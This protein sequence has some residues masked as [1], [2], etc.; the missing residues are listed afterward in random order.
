MDRREGSGGGVGGWAAG[1]IADPLPPGETVRVRTARRPVSRRASILTVVPI[2]IGALLGP[3][4]GATTTPTDTAVRGAP[5]WSEAPG[6]RSARTPDVSV[7]RGRRLTL[8]ATA[9]TRTLAGKRS[10]RTG[11]SLVVGVPTPDRKSTRLNSSH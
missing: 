4:A 5:E 7:S 9:L 6:A 10:G 11:E 1:W 3:A 8:D 2:A